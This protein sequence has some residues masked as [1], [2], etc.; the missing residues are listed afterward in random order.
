MTHVELAVGRR[1]ARRISAAPLVRWITPVV[2]LAVVA[3]LILYPIARLLQ[4]ALADGGAAYRDA[5]EVNDLGRIVATTALLAVGSL[6]IAMV[7]G[8]TLGIA[9]CRLPQRV[10]WLSTLPLLPL[11]IPAVANIVGWAML[12]SPR[13]GYINTLL[14]WMLQMDPKGTGPIDIY[15]T[16]GIIISTGLALTSFVYVFVRGGLMNINA[17][18]NDAAA[19]SGASPFVTIRT[20]TVPVIRPAL[21]YGAGVALLLGLGQFTA[22]LLL[23]VNGNVT[24]LSNAIYQRAAEPPIDYGVAAALASPLLATGIV[25]VIVQRFALRDRARYVTHAGR[26]A[27]RP[28]RPSRWAV[29][30]IVVHAVVAIVLPVGALIVVALSPFYSRDIDM[31]AFS[32]DNFRAVLEDP[33]LFDGI[34]TSVFVSVAAVLIVLVIGYLVAELL[35]SEWLPSW[36]RAVLE[37]VTFLP[38]GVPAVVFGAGFL[39]AYSQDPVV[40]YGTDTVLVVVYVTLMIPYA[41]RLISAARVSLGSE[42]AAASRTSVPA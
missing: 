42:Y 27:P 37:F 29:V 12:F 6:V 7:L 5:L 28:L 25:I 35:E 17:E 3:V 41:T 26:S 24:V 2:A 34:R 32:L 40:L 14:R 10:Q 20:I 1:A 36:F 18:L 39:F 15:T 30:P 23:G 21:V 13:V 38:V 16:Y 4:K 9:S 22:P 31:A 11:V 19:A 8:V 33:G